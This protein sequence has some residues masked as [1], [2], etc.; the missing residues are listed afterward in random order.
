M[1]FLTDITTQ[2]VRDRIKETSWA[3]RSYIADLYNIERLIK[4]GGIKS[5]M[6]GYMFKALSSKYPV[7][8]ECIKKELTTGE[9]T[10]PE[11]FVTVKGERARQAAAEE[12]ARAERRAEGEGRSL[13]LW[14]RMGGRP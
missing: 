13:D 12:A 3:G 1:E 8:W 14:L 11:E 9:L 7:E 4:Q 5:V 10:S 6:Q 2:F